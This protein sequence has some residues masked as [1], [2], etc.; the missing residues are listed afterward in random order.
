M[1]VVNEQQQEEPSTLSGWPWRRRISYLLMTAA[2]YLLALGMVPY[3]WSKI[4]DMQFQVGASTYAKRLGESSGGALAWA[5]LGYNPSFQI[6]LGVLE[7]V[8]ALLLLSTRMRRLG[9]VLMFPVL[10]NVVLVNFFFGLWHDTKV[11]SSVLLGLNIFLLAYDWRLFLRL[12]KELIALPLIISRRPLRIAM[13]VTATVLPVAG[14]LGFIIFFHW[15]I[16]ASEDP[17][18]DLI[19]VPQVNRA[20]TWKIA[21]LIVDGKPVNVDSQIRVYFDFWQACSIWDGSQF[22]KGSFKANRAQH[23]LHIEKIP[24]GGDS[25]PLDGV[26]RTEGDRLFFDAHQGPKPVKL[27]LSREGWGRQSP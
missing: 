22:I 26:Y 2:R 1:P 8:P 20:G 13:R 12:S 7:G 10:L 6:L 23:T 16:K 5:Y 14:I 24:F 18:S 11:L 15:Q 3:A 27:T 25:A 9:A 4:S 21:S 19:G 17:I